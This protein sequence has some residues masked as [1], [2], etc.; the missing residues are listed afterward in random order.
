MGNALDT[1]L[2]LASAGLPVF[3]CRPGTKYPATKHG[4]K[5]ASVDQ[6]QIKAWWEVNPNYNLAMAVPGNMVVVD[7]EGN[8]KKELEDIIGCEFPETKAVSTPGHGGGV[9]L[10]Y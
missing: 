1:A 2:T 3:P 6:D 8:A 9:H 10:W 4:L 7:F 5:D